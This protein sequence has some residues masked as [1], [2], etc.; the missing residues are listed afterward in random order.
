MTDKVLFNSRAVKKLSARSSDD[1]P[2][3]LNTLSESV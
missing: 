1:N 2:S 3:V